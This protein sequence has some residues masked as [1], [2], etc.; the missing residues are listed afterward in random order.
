M[1][2]LSAKDLGSHAV[3]VFVAMPIFGGILLWCMRGAQEG[4]VR[5]CKHMIRLESELGLTPSTEVRAS[6]TDPY[7]GLMILGLLFSVVAASYFFL[8]GG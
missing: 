5:A 7:F 8:V 1:S 3:V 4:Y 2:G 6:H